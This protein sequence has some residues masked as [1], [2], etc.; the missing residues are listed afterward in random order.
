MD[1]KLSEILNIRTVNPDKV[2]AI[3]KD[4]D[5]WEYAR[6]SIMDAIATGNDAMGELLAISK[7]SNHP[8]A[9]EV[10]TALLK[11][12]IAG[13]KVLMETKRVNQQIEQDAGGGGPQTIHNN[14]FVG[15]TAE[16]AK[17]LEAKRNPTQERP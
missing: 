2:A 15:S 3:A 5:E 10:L 13:S 4:T 9:Y 11:E 8:A 16:L 17:I 6:A 12:V 1:D 14:M 7:A